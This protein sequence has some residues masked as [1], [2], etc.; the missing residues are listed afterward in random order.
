VPDVRLF[1]ALRPPPAA[2]ASLAAALAG[3]RTGEVARWHV[4][5]AFLG[6]LPAA[7]PLLP[8]LDRAA[9]AVPPLPLR[10]SGGGSFRRS[11]VTWAGLAG[12]V[13]GLRRLADRVAGACREAGV[14]LE[15]RPFRAHL[16]VGRRSAV[17]PTL[18][19]SYEGPEWTAT[20]IELVRS[21]LGQRPVHTVLHRSPLTG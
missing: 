4:T 9:A 20:E 16:T 15:E 13:D 10:L 12:D 7:E 6:E 11:G 5:L 8:G 19:A 3:R 1:V 21:V 18:L 14:V 2:C 17:E